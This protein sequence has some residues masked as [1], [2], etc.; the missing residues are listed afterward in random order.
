MSGPTPIAA[1][2]RSRSACR[3][4]LAETLAEVVPVYQA[5]K[6]S[7]NDNYTTAQPAELA[8]V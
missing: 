6:D 3:A 8:V 2:R 7:G 4:N 1:S 5:A